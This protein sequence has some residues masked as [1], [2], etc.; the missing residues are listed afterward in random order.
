M[1]F[2]SA[3]VFTN[4]FRCY[5]VYLPTTLRM[6]F[7]KGVVVHMGDCLIG[8]KAISNS[9]LTNSLASACEG[10]WLPRVAQ[11]VQVVLCSN[12]LDNGTLSS[13]EVF[14]ANKEAEHPAYCNV[15]AMIDKCSEAPGA[16]RGTSASFLPEKAEMAPT[17]GQARVSSPPLDDDDDDG[18]GDLHAPTCL[19]LIMSRLRPSPT[20]TPLPPPTRP[21]RV[22]AAGTLFLTHTLSLPA[23]PGP[24]QTIRAHEYARSRGGSAPA[25]LAVLSQLNADRCW[26][27]ASLGSA[28]EARAVARELEAEGVS[29]RY[30]KVWEG[31]GVPAAWILHAGESSVFLLASCWSPRREGGLLILIRLRRRSDC[32]CGRPC[33]TTM[34]FGFPR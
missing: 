34:C 18:D 5:G 26:L 21:L 16:Y 11:Y 20:P 31:A 29:T 1:I 2:H 10:N 33:G 32:R 24:G 4:W 22:V 27:V 25:V 17:A 23:H 9:S 28:Q 14:T 3:A 6:G 7:W 30:C 19:T 12:G 13:G 8:G 15:V